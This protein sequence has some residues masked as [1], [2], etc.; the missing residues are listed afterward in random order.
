MKA[1]RS[2][3][4]GDC[5]PH[6][7]RTATIDTRPPAV[8]ADAWVAGTK[9]LDRGDFD[10]IAGSLYNRNKAFRTAQLAVAARR[11]IDK[12]GV[13]VSDRDSARTGA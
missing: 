4:V 12:Q 10:A 3:Q 8:S 6:Q 11:I 2:P 7:V 9:C 13:P 1:F 5:E